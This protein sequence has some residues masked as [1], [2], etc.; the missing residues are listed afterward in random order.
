MARNAI[1]TAI[2]VLSLPAA[3]A[4]P[5][6]VCAKA[7][8]L[9]VTEQ[10]VGEAPTAL[11]A[12][13]HGA[14]RVTV[15]GFL[16][17]SALGTAV[18]TVLVTGSEDLHTRFFDAD[19]GDLLYE[20]KDAHVDRGAVWSADEIVVDRKGRFVVTIGGPTDPIAY[21]PRQSGGELW[22]DRAVLHGH[23]RGGVVAVTALSDSAYTISA[24]GQVGVWMWNGRSLAS[25]RFKSCNVRGTGREGAS[26]TAAALARNGDYLALGTNEGRVFRVSYE[27]LHASGH[28]VLHGQSPETLSPVGDGEVTALAYGRNGKLFAAFIDGDRQATLVKFDRRLQVERRYAGHF[29]GEVHQ[30]LFGAGNTLISASSAPESTI[31]LWRR[32]LVGTMQ[33]EHD[34]GTYAFGGR[35][36]F[37]GIH[38]SAVSPDGRFLVTGSSGGNVTVW[39]VASGRPV[40]NFRTRGDVRGLAFDATGRWLFTGAHE[41]DARLWSFA[42][43][44]APAP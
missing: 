13:A 26:V 9:P 2:F 10:Q 33:V 30:L 3:A 29:G 32:R 22:F 25:V 18:K 44:V 19:T 28:G 23:S 4:T 42:S 40:R 35:V 7:M 20:D 6:V 24:A 34:P 5:A 16:D 36:A 11:R 41:G 39:N 37:D 1:L 17:I 31:R 27:A 43:L 8:V 14:R 12:F 38:A 15:G 21:Y